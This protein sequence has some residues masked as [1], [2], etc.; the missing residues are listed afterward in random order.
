MKRVFRL[1]QSKRRL[2]DDLEQEFRFHLEGRIEDLMA[3]DGLSREAAE[4]EARRRFGDEQ[5]YRQAARDFDQSTLE[6]ARR[7]DLVDAIRRETRHAARSL[8]RSPAFSVLAALTLALGLG[9]ATTI[10]ALLDRVVLRP[11]PYANADRLVHI[12]TL[13]PK[14]KAG[15]EYGISR[16]QYFFFKKNSSALSD[17]IFYDG[18]AIVVPGD[19]EHPAERVSEIGVSANA[20]SLLGIRPARGRVFSTESELYSADAQRVGVISYEY[21]QRRFGGDPKVV[22]TRLVTELTK[23]IEIIG[24]LPPNASLP[25][26]HADIW[27]PNHLDPSAPPINNHTHHGIGVLRPGVT[28]EAAAR[29]VARMQQLMTAAYP[30][31]YPQGFLDRTGFAMNLTPLHDHVVGATITKTL[32]LVFAGVGLVLLIAAANVANLF[33]VRIDTRRREVAVRAA[34]GASRAHLAIHYVTESVLLALAA[35]AGAI[36]VGYTLL[37]VVLVIAPQSLPRLAEVS[38]DVRGVAFCAALSLAFALVFGL[39]PL[40]A[41]AVD[42]T[43]LREGGRGLTTSSRREAARRGLVLSQIALAVTLLSGAALMALSFARLRGVQPGLDPTGVQA[44]EIILPYSRYQEPA[45]INAFWHELSRRVEAVP[46]VLHAGASEDL[47][48]ADSGGCSGILTDVSDAGAERGN[49]MPMTFITP[50]YLEA[51]GIKVRGALPTW[52][53]VEAGEGPAIVTAA[54]SKRFWGREQSALG[55]SVKPYNDKLPYSPIVGIAEDVRS[56]GLQAPPIEEVFFPLIGPPGT[57]KWSMRAM[58]FVVRAPTLSQSSVVGSV[59]RILESIDKQVPIADVESMETLV[60]KSM[61]QTSFTMLLL[62]IASA[63]ALMLSAVGIYGVI[64]YLV[65]QRRGEIGIRMALGAQQGQVARLIV[66]QSLTL[67]CIGAAIGVL[68]ALVST[69]LLRSLLFEVSATNPGVLAGAALVLIAV[70]TVAT[71]GPVRKAAKIDP[72]EAMRG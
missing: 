8:A 9:A 70:A 44:M 69:R 22:G 27:V 36:V 41:A 5:E 38:F 68:V 63:I 71:L 72:V 39:L 15:E 59:R 57:T 24:V 20:F 30:N 54:F 21:W 53:S 26:A 19:G 60:A 49:C 64:S 3:R 37:R 2:D 12:G 7:I 31:V 42:S 23:A 65:G 40:G 28:V 14:V 1:P 47:P 52:S 13:W 35:G 51:V 46:G 11:L 29:D 6:R 34:L 56:N 25:M 62:I 50:G 55:R 32:W 45:Q 48:F 61:A 58:H 43:M 67:A 18:D 16:G 17:V 10:F 33:L 4:R 66:G